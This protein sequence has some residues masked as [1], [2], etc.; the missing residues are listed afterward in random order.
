MNKDLIIRWTILIL[1][2]VIG[3][4]VVRMCSRKLHKTGANMFGAKNRI[5]W[6]S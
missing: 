5:E 3:L 1:V 2:L 4:L 6:I